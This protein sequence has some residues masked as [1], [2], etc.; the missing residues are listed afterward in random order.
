MSYL[1]VNKK[2]QPQL[3]EIKDGKPLALMADN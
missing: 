1:L 2:I 3:G